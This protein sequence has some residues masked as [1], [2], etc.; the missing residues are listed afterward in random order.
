MT[1]ENISDSACR[2]DFNRGGG[3]AVFTE[4]NRDR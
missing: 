3:E 4:I 1:G 2:S